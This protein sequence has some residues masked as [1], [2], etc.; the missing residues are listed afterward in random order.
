[1]LKTKLS[2]KIYTNIMKG[3][4]LSFV[5]VLLCVGV[6]DAAVRT[7]NSIIRNKPQSNIRTTSI[8]R[9]ATSRSN[10]VTSR[11]TK[12]NTVSSRSVRSTTQQYAPNTKQNIYILIYPVQTCLPITT[13]IPSYIVKCKAGACET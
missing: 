9:S 7:T 2:D 10:T 5:T 1:L 11:T 12:S 8:A 13:I 4:I 3:R 6:A